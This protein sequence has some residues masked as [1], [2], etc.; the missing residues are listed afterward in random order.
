MTVKAG[1]NAAVWYGTDYKIGVGNWT[2]DGGSRNMQAI[3]QF[4]DEDIQEI[5]L[6]RSG[7]S[8]TITGNYLVDSDAGQKQLK[9]DYDAGT[10]ITNL[11][12]YTDKTNSI[13]L[14]PSATGLNGGQSHLIVT[15]THNVSAD[16]SSVGTFSATL[17]V[18]GTL[19]QVGSTTAVAVAT[20]GEVD[21]TAAAV[22]L[23]GSLIHRG[24]EAGNLDCYFEYGK[25][26]SFGSDTKGTE[27]VFTTPD[28]GEYDDESLVALDADTLYYYRAVCELADTSKV[29]GETMSFTTTA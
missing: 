19:E 9:I 22:T 18:N 5:P 10:E 6:Q 8:I 3:D 23:W 17:R 2:W 7:G 11:R 26:L 14:T 12:L 16:K 13:Y 20:L 21:V 15:N 25:T 4:A 27:T 24:G 29:Y 28:K 1:H